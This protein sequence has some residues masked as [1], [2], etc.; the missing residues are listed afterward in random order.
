VPA[1]VQGWIK[2]K[3]LDL[4]KEPI[5]PFSFLLFL[6]FKPL[7]VLLH[8]LLPLRDGLVHLQH[9][10]HGLGPLQDTVD[11]LVHLQHPGTVLATCRT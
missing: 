10:G 2:E 3:G 11:R 4:A 9:P 5:H 8:G 1:A 6:L 7:A